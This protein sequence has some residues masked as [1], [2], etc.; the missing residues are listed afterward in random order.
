MSSPSRSTAHDAWEGL[1]G[2]AILRFGDIEL[3]SIKCLSLIP[4]DKIEEST[5]RL[6]FG[7]RAALLVEILEA[8]KSLDDHLK[9]IRDGMKRAMTLA[10]TRNLIAHNPVMLDLYVNED[11]TESVARHSITSARSEGQTLT[12]EDLE[13]FA[14][15]VEGL[16][17]ELWLAF[18][19]F[20]GTS[21]HLWRNRT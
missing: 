2:K 17:S 9:T 19:N 1:V 20:A 16:S 8:R 15:E 7:R 11:E 14:S 18:L 21:E 12:L 6:D 5:S 10:K 3:I 4:S 13:E